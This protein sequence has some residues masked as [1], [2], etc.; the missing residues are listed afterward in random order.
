MKIK[1]I[2]FTLVILVSFNVNAFGDREA[3]IVTDSVLEL[4][5]GGHSKGENSS[6]DISGNAN[7]TTVL[8]KK[9]VEI[10]LDGEVI[11]TQ[12]EWKGI[13]PLLPEKFDA[14]VY[15]KCV[16]DLTPQFLSKFS[17]SNGNNVDKTPKV[18]EAKWTLSMNLPQG[19]SGYSANVPGLSN[20]W[21][22]PNCDCSFPKVLPLPQIPYSDNSMM[23]I[24]NNCKFKVDIAV[25][26]VIPTKPI[27]VVSVARETLHPGSVLKADVGGAIGLSFL[28][29]ECP[30]T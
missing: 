15:T 29:K 24:G 10:G 6:I 4:C 14:S 1:L 11:F 16:T 28:L 23:E 22:G 9:L 20:G 21:F 8:L 30:N 2:F 7:A 13:E 12:S 27:N 19:W 5:R 3:K 25:A 17:G 18:H 26:K